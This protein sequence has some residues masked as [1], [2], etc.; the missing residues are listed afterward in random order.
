[1][2]PAKKALLIFLRYP[3][4]GRVKSRLA[5]AIGP[6]EAAHV[7]EKL[8]RRTLGVA[9]LGPAVDGGFYLIGLNHPCPPAFL[10][11]TWGTADVFKR[12]EQLL[13]N[14]GFRVWRLAERKD[15]DRLDD[16]ANLR[17]QPWFDTTISIIIPTVR[18]LVQL[19]PLLL[20]HL[21]QQIWPGD[22]I[23]IITVTGDDDLPTHT[24]F[25]E[26]TPQIRCATALRGRGQQLNRGAELSRGNLLFFPH[27]DSI[28]PPNFAHAIRKLCARP[29][30]SLGC[31]SLAF[32]PS[33]RLLDGIARWA[34]LR[35]RLFG[36]PYGD[37]G[38][39]CRR[40]VFEK[41][42]GF[43]KLYLQPPDAV[44]LSSRGQ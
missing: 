43:K 18:P 12:T 15:V 35:T 16:L 33:Q 38:L 14:S 25:L 13:A 36:L 4:P 21:Q 41:A 10:P 37:Q 31:F 32:S 24:R 39:F 19:G 22:E 29:E 1:M 20:R 2:R 17:E 30:I 27:D 5:A 7:Y 44:F 9:A 42:G 3:E 34:N 40:E 26:V 6:A 8:T 11:E 28:P 23:L